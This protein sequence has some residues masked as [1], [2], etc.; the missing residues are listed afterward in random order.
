[1]ASD[2]EKMLRQISRLG[3]ALCEY[4]ERTLTLE[5]REYVGMRIELERH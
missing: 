3:I 1:V 4:K 2:S 5:M